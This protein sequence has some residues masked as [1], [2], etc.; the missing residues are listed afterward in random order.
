MVIFVQFIIL[1]V[2]IGLAFFSFKQ[3]SFKITVKRLT[4]TAFMVILSVILQAYSL[5][6]AVFNFDAFRVGI[7][8]LPLMLLGAFFGLPWALIGGF[9]QDLLGL[10]LDPTGFPFLGFTLNKILYALI[11][12]FWFHHQLMSSQTTFKL[13]RFSL[14][15]IYL[16]AISVILLSPNL[17]INGLIISQTNKWYL[18]LAL[19]ILLIGIIY[20]LNRLYSKKD[21]NH[22]LAYSRWII[23]VV[24]VE[25]VVK[26]LATPTWLALMYKVPFITSLILRFMTSSLMMFVYIVLGFVLYRVM[27]QSGL[28]DLS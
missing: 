15:F 22:A 13:A 5:K 4:Y 19:A 1:A 8:Q 10:L 27:E 3:P 18:A 6:I 12:A 14:V 16:S 21:Q 25:V 17:D 26:Y 7:T 2:L 23:S 24:S 20:L 9:I 28:K 11:P